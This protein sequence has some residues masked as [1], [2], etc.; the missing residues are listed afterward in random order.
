[1]L[2]TIKKRTMCCNVKMC[3]MTLLTVE[4]ISLSNL[5]GTMSKVQKE[6][7]VWETILSYSGIIMG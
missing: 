2:K 3:R 4:N 6:A 7:L 1:M 5:V